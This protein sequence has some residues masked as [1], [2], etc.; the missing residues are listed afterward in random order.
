MHAGELLSGYLDAELTVEERTQ[1]E[2]HLESCP[3]CRSE[4][5]GIAA[6]RTRLRALPPLEVP[7]GLYDLPAPVVPLRRRSTWRRAVGVAAAATLVVGIGAGVLNNDDVP[8]QLE[9][10]VDQHVA[11]ASVDPGLNV[12]Q[13]QAVFER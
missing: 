3:E 13:V 11:R 10:A 7:A 1:V 8:L 2:N 12:V 4:L 6:I 9:Q 5:E